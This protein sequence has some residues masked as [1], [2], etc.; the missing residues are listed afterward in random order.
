MFERYRDRVDA[1]GI[2]VTLVPGVFPI[3]SFEAVSRFAERCGATMPAAIAARFARVGDD[4]EVGH[5]LAAHLAA[6]Q[7]DG[8]RSLGVEHVHVYTLNR[9]ALALAVCD[10]LAVGV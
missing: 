9:A 3:H 5:N 7:I 4:I 8:L 2:D 6:R 10:R 1:R